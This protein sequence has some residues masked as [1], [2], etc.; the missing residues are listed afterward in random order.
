MHTTAMGQ[1]LKTIKNLTDRI[2]HKGEFRAVLKWS[3]AP[4]RQLNCCCAAGNSA[5]SSITR[6]ILAV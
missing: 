4:L 5:A 3:P 2:L 1:V 6:K